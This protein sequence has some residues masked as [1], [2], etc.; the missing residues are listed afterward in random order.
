MP[1]TIVVVGSYLLLAGL[2]IGSFV[3]LAA[4]R[5]PR[6][7]SL[8]HPG[9]HCTACGRHLNVVDLLP[10]VG[11]LVRRGRCASC[12]AP[13]GIS[14]PLVEAACGAIM[15]APMLWS[16]GWPEA[17]AGIFL[18]AGFGAGM[19]LLSVLSRSR[20]GSR[21]DAGSAPAPLVR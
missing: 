2:A 7:E 10:V 20:S 18:T 11:Y 14:S 15:V 19:I 6:G 12:R 1:V 9:S 17:L 3:N 13:I 8:L 16:P 21:R 5:L 4:D